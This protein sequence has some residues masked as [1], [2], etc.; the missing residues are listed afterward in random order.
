MVQVKLDAA[1]QLAIISTNA[2]PV[3]CLHN[4]LPFDSTA[5]NLAAIGLNGLGKCQIAKK[6]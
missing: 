5:F 3:R 6:Q 2:D 1:R 4:M